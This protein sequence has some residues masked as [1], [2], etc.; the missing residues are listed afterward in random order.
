MFGPEKAW[1]NS[2]NGKAGWL[3]PLTHEYSDGSSIT[4]QVSTME[5]FLESL[6]RDYF[7]QPKGEPDAYIIAM[8][9]KEKK[10]RKIANQLG[11]NTAGVKAVNGAKVRPDMKF[12]KKWRP[13]IKSWCDKSRGCYL[14]HMK[15]YHDFLKTDKEIVMVLED[16]ANL[17]TDKREFDKFVEVSK[18]MMTKDKPMISFAGLCWPKF[19]KEI[20]DTGMHEYKDGDCTHGFLINRKAARVLLDKPMDL[21]IDEQIRTSDEIVKIIPN[22]FLLEQSWTQ[23]LN[24]GYGGF[25]QQKPLKSPPEPFSWPVFLLVG[26]GLLFIFIFVLF[27]MRR[28]AG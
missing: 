27:M 12:I 5:S 28:R 15:V 14:S 7:L 25:P 10:A 22:R 11:M 17:V 8:P 6:P 23:E 4:A 18:K 3:D 16:D 19:G 20:G 24:E 1:H 13:K 21:P 26:I 2:R 9:D